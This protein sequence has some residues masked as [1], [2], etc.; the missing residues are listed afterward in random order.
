MPVPLSPILIL[1]NLWTM[2]LSALF[3][4]GLLFVNN[5]LL[6]MVLCTRL[7]LFVDMLCVEGPE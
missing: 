4:F 6:F 7:L 5:L 3:V 1:F 2:Y